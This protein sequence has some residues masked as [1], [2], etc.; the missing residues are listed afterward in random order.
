MQEIFEEN[1]SKIL[2]GAIVWAP[3]LET[4]NVY[5]AKEHEIGF[6][7]RR[8]M[9]F[10]DPVRIFGQL[11]SQ[12]LHLKTSIAWDVYLV[13]PPDHSWETELPPQPKFWMHQLDEEPTL[14]L[15]P[16]RIK[17]AV[18]TMIEKDKHE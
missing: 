17:R 11:M 2:Y 12:T 8:V 5:A 16:L 6:S 7:D 3:M 9:Q 18:Q 15:D 10:W 14:F 13:Y 1:K 4:D